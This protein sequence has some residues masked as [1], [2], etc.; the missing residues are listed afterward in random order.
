MHT[1]ARDVRDTDWSQVLALYDQFVHLGPS[2]IIALNWAIAVAEL[3]DPQV[4]WPPSTGSRTSWPAITP[5]HADLLRR[6]LDHGNKGGG[7]VV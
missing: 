4:H 3:N 7:R 5:P 1:C 2:P 6:Q